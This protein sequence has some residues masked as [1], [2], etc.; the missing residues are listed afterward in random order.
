MN[1]VDSKMVCNEIADLFCR[2]SYLKNMGIKINNLPQIVIL[3]QQNEGKSTLIEAITNVQILPKCEGLCTRK[4]IYMTLINE[5]DN[6]KGVRIIIDDKE[7]DEMSAAEEIKKK[8]VNEKIKEISCTIISPHVY[9]CTIV[10]TVGLI[11]VSEQDELLDPKKIK[12]DT[13]E[14]LKGENNIFVLVSSAPSDLANSQMLQLIRKYKRCKDTLGVMTKIDLVGNQNHQNISDI[15]RGKNYKLGYGWITT[16]LRSDIDIKNGMT[17][18]E[19]VISEYE[20]FQNSY[21]SQYPFGVIQVRKTI[22]QVQLEKI[23]N[24]IP[25]IIMEI[26]DKIEKLRG[27][28]NFLDRI[29]Y[30]SDDAIAKKLSCMIENLVGSSHERFLFENRLRHKLHDFLIEFMDKIYNEDEDDF[31]I[32]QNLSP[33]HIDPNIYNYHVKN[34]TTPDKLLLSE[35]I[36]ELLNTGM[37]THSNISNEV[38]EK[39]FNNEASLASLMLA[40]DLDINDP[41]GHNK[42]SWNKYLEKFFSSLQSNNTLCDNVYQIT[43]DMLLEYIENSDDDDDETSRNFTEYIV[44]NI[45]HNTFEEKMRYSISCLVNIEQRPYI[46]M[47]DIIKQVIKITKSSYLDYN[48]FYTI[49]RLLSSP[50]SNKIELK[51]FSKL[52]N[53][54]YLLTVIDRLS[55]NCYRIVAV[56]LVNKMV[57]NLL[58]MFLNLNK[59]TSKQENEIIN[60][61]I[62]VLQNIKD[63]FLNFC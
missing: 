24:T 39:S 22:S 12:K 4:P 51:L 13:I 63:I 3:G 20:Y 17:I 2:L 41:M 19:S 49:R 21:L 61:K 9:N 62:N 14:Y 25:S 56:N 50:N 40:F 46:N 29:I 34:S 57:E 35:D 58:H 60:Q 18:E 32:E 27:S 37:L 8:N 38:L 44:K 47:F 52:W 55:F 1:N 59:E 6:K 30:E 43:E 36:H 45:G 54:A 7:Y 5:R 31:Q 26:D 23:R 10:D 15:L 48:Q 28:Q 16:K 53:R 11:Q 42:F 33:N